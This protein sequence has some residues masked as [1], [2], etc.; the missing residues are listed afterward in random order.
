MLE[1][2]VYFCQQERT[3]APWVLPP[4]DNQW[5]RQP[6]RWMSASPA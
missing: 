2:L 6:M 5:H 4:G 1:A 3:D